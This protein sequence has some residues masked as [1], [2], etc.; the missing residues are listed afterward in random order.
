MADIQKLAEMQL[1]S[2]G[3]AAYSQA[4]HA[5]EDQSHQLGSGTGSQGRS[6][7]FNPS[8]VQAIA[9]INEGSQ[10]GKWVILALT[11]GKKITKLVSMAGLAAKLPPGA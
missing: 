9:G 4:G 3:L 10:S 8:A 6:R 5:C 11:T 2:T 1:G 7:G